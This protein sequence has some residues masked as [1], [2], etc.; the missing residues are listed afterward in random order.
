M[1]L[2]RIIILSIFILAVFIM[3]AVSAEDN[4]TDADEEIAQDI[5]VSF[6]EKVYEEDLGVI[7]VNLPENAEGRLKATV[8][9]VEI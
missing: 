2:N 5:N 6:P 4:A 9:D 7:D 3:G 1:K 8:D